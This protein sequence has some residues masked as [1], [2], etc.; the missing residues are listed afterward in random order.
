MIF[1]PIRRTI[2]FIK[3]INFMRYIKLILIEIFM[4]IYCYMY[5]N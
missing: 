2:L 4:I 5:D 1:N 3:H